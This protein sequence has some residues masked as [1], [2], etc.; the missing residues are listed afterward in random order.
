MLVLQACIPGN[1]AGGKPVQ[2]THVSGAARVVTDDQLAEEGTFWNSRP[3]VVLTDREANVVVDLGADY[4]LRALVV[5]ADNDDAYWVEGSEDGSSWRPLWRAGPQ[6]GQGLRT[7]WTETP[8]SAARYLRVR[9]DG[10]DGNF[11]LSELRA[12]CLKPA[13]WP[14]IKVPL[15]RLPPQ[16]NEE[17]RLAV[18]R[19]LISGAAILLLVIGL[20]YRG[21]AF[22]IAL[23]TLGILAFACFFS[24]GRFHAG[25]FI[26]IWEHYHY[27]V[28]GKYFPELGYTRIYQCTAIAEHENGDRTVE[29]RKL[30][31]LT[32]NEIEPN[33]ETL[34]HPEICKEHFTP[35][36]W[37]QFKADVRFFHSVFGS[38]KFWEDSQIDHGYN[39]TPFWTLFG[40]AFARTGPAS[41]DQIFWLALL[42]PALLIGM[43]I[44]VAWAFG[45]RTAALAL[46]VWGTNHPARYFWNGGAYLRM[47]WLAA[48]ICGIAMVK[49]DRPATGG[50]LIAWSALLRIFPGF[51]IGGV[52]LKW[53]WRRFVS[54]EAPP[55]DV[56]TKRLVAGFAIM[57]FAGVAV[58]SLAF[59]P[60]S[61]AG[62][63][64][65]SKKHVGTPLTNNMGWKTVV[66]W[67]EPT[68]ARH[69]RDYSLVDPFH[70]WKEARRRLFRQ[71]FVLYAAGIL[72]FC[73]L[74]GWAAARESDLIA[75]VLG[76]GLIPFGAELTCYYY[77]FMLAYA[78]LWQRDKRAGVLAVILAASSSWVAASLGWDDDAYTAIGAVW[79]VLICAMTYLI[80][81]TSRETAVVASTPPTSGSPGSEP[82][83]DEPTRSGL[84]KGAA[85]RKK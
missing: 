58:S 73:A 24:W 27:Y 30:R 25:R 77:S 2:A 68:N 32:T 43:W 22:D 35:E 14:P 50:V 36:R 3:A 55:Y 8:E 62:F 53:L 37:D 40:H 56:A 41:E 48:L 42:D 63:A 61:W 69:L 83:R 72:G 82:A 15:F 39:A 10:G 67:S 54:K 45:W 71:R 78:F 13:E 20:R 76:V 79:I 7:R 47:D 44:C 57:L 51:I 84:P 6:A 19:S 64:A 18:A 74:V 46:I 23:A 66:A 26:H 17:D 80:G 21:R 59:G 52:I 11:S 1:L 34:A 60:K 38:Q 65:N 81:K 16:W 12:Y 29:R 28:G 5:Q 9:G 33:A 70:K 49:K 85:R 4:G 31:N 75:L